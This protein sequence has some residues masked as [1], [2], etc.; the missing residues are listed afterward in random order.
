MHWVDIVVIAIV[1]LMGIRGLVQGF[2][3][4]VMGTAALFGGLIAALL[5]L[6]PVSEI[7]EPHLG[8]AFYVPIIAFLIVFIVVY[9]VF[10]VLESLFTKMVE[11][12]SLDRL[13]KAMGLFFGVVQGAVLVLLIFF[14]LSIQ[15][16][17]DAD[18]L[19]TDSV[20]GGFALQ[21]M[22]FAEDLLNPLF[23]EIQGSVETSALIGDSVF[24]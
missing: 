24:V 22:P 13:D 21:L 1:A 20:S 3:K 8:T 12:S 10:K 5:L 16:L 19:F 15:P 23:D 17:F 7:L 14:V 9:I 11:A 4:G 2:T 6:R 18:F